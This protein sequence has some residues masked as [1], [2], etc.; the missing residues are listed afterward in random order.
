MHCNKH[1]EVLIFVYII[2]FVQCDV[3]QL[4]KWAII[5]RLYNMYKIGKLIFVHLSF[6]CYGRGG[7]VIYLLVNTLV[8]F[9]KWKQHV[10]L[11]C[12][13]YCYSSVLQV[14]SNIKVH[15]HRWPIIPFSQHQWTLSKNFQ[16]GLWLTPAFSITQAGAIWQIVFLFFFYLAS[17]VLVTY[18]VVTFASPFPAFSLIH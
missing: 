16:N 4:V 9:H 12:F 1:K 2:C 14:L 10:L 8:T 7:G 6:V 5:W 11:N 15:I 3:M 18:V 13:S 17:C